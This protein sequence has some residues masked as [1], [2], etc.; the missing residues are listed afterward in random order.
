MKT[1]F[2]L[3]MILNISPPVRAQYV[4]EKSPIVI[5]IERGVVPLCCTPACADSIC[6]TLPIKRNNKTQTVIILIPQIGTGCAVRVYQETEYYKYKNNAEYLD[7]KCK[8]QDRKILIDKQPLS[9]NLTELEDG[10]YIVNY[11]ADCGGLM[12]VAIVTE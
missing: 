8:I 9:L 1:F 12:R 5:S 6:Y 4:I 10:N 3:L 2:I 7:W 11:S